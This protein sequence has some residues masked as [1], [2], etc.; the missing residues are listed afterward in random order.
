MENTITSISEAFSMQP[1][2]LRIVPEDKYQ[3]YWDKESACK[4][5]K[6]ESRQVDSDKACEFVI[7]YNYEGKVLFEYLRS[8]VNIHYS[9][10]L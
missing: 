9:N 2:T 1:V 4:E 3:N 6:I 8:S 7:G 5:M 10:N